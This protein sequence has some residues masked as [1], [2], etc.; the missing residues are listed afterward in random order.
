M[1]EPRLPPITGSHFAMKPW[2]ILFCLV[3]VVLVPA[4]VKVMDQ[5]QEF[6]GQT[7][8]TAATDFADSPVTGAPPTVAAV[9]TVPDPAPVPTP[10]NSAA[11][12]T[13]AESAL[14]KANGS[15]QRVVTL[16]RT[17]VLY[18]ASQP[19]VG[20]ALL[21]Q[22]AAELDLYS[23]RR[24]PSNDAVGAIPWM[25]VR[26]LHVTLG[27]RYRQQGRPAEA[28]QWL[29]RAVTASEPLPETPLKEIELHARLMADDLFLLAHAH[30][31]TGDLTKSRSVMAKMQ[32]WCAKLVN[33]DATSGC[34]VPIKTSLC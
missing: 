10:A 6:A 12:Y 13:R 21:H 16:S 8:Q 15:S 31:A 9:E 1:D 30:C 34:Q 33:R 24:D 20:A 23:A 4:L 29:R 2:Q 11:A 7:A 19:E 22:A 17:G 18:S 14:A 28:E 3:C 32:S 26:S 25:L 27:E 5:R